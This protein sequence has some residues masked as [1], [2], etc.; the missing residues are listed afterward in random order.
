MDEK[1]KKLLDD[2]ITKV[3]TNKMEEGYRTNN[4]NYKDLIDYFETDVKDL[5]ILDIT[6]KLRKSVDENK[7]IFDELVKYTSTGDYSTEQILGQIDKLSATGQKNHGG[8]SVEDFKKGLANKFIR[9]NNQAKELRRIMGNQGQ[10]KSSIVTGNTIN[11][12]REDLTPEQLIAR[13]IG[14]TSA[15]PKSLYDE[16]FAPDVNQVPDQMSEQ[17]IKNYY[18]APVDKNLKNKGHVI[19]KN[20]VQHM[21]NNYLVYDLETL[22]SRGNVSFSPSQ[23]AFRGKINGNK[24]LYNSFIKIARSSE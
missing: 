16:S 1:N 10:G 14:V 7:G 21:K 3:L 18:E 9:N 22:G 5:S 15:I 2:I 11:E 17:S 19:S 6:S 23:I 20:D 8:I 12:G 13:D 4:E 24:V